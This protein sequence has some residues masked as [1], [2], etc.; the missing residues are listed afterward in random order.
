MTGKWLTKAERKAIRA[1]RL[2]G[3]SWRAIVKQH[4][5]SLTTAMRHGDNKHALY[6]QRC[7]RERNAKRK[8][9]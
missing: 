5:V 4:N 6:Q 3:K 2:E 7:E 8:K 9:K 1:S